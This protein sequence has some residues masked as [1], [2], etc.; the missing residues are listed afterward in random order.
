VP[1]A[2]DYHKAVVFNNAIYVGGGQSDTVSLYR[3]DV[4]HPDTDK[5]DDPIETPQSLFALTVFRNNLILVGGKIKNGRA[6]N[7]LFCLENKHWKNYAEMPTARWTPTAASHI[8]MMI[9]MGGW[10]SNISKTKIAVNGIFSITEVYDSHSRQWFKCDDLPQPLCVL[11]SAIVGT[12][13]FV[14]GGVTPDTKPSSAVYVAL[15]ETLS[16][17]R[18]K[19]ERVGD[20]PWRNSAAASLGN[21]YLIA[22]GGYSEHFTACVFSDKYSWECIGTLPT[23]L[24]S[25][26]AVCSGGQIFVIGGFDEIRKS[27]NTV[28]IGTIHGTGC[29]LL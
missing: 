20:T 26:A 29:T 4:Y 6:T 15:L 5:W 21:R 8:S 17:H 22:V 24:C 7:R 14:L 11:H 2:E 10:D 25:S 12:K 3:V 28:Y 27:S 1:V 23:I 16:D 18:L 9:V 13:L 19:W